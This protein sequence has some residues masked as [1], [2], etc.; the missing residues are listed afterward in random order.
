M[1]GVII[2]AAAATL[3]LAGCAPVD[4][5]ADP[6]IAAPPPAA[7]TGTTSAAPTAKPSSTTR[8]VTYKIG[9]TATQA[10]ITYATPSGQEQQNGARVP[11]H[12]TFKV[13]KGSFAVLVVS[14]QNKGGGTITCE[15]D[16]DGKQVKAA[17]SSG[18]YAI[19]SCDH[20]LG[21]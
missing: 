6:N 21:L 15:I 14:A 3:L 1:R 5:T 19:A 7:A 4:N 18:A 11:W 9:G 16:V 12:K 8:T 17:K 13:K 20:P 10:L 2:A